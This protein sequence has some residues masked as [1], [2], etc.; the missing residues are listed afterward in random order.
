LPEAEALYR[1]ILEAEPNHADA[2]HLLGVIAHQT[3]KH[4]VAVEYITRAIALNPAAAEYHCNIGEAYRALARLNEAGSSFQ[5]ALALNPASAEAMNN[6]GAVLQEQGK[7]EEAVAHYRQAVALK[8]DYA[9]AYNNLGSALLA[10][11]K[12]EEAAT[13]I[14]QALALSPSFA[15]AHHNLGI[16]LQRKGHL[17][18]AVAQYRHALAL[19][20]DFAE[21]RISLGDYLKDVGKLDEAVVCY[22][23]AVTLNPNMVGAYNNLGNALRDQGKLDEAIA[24]YRQALAINPHHAGVHSNIVLVMS[25]NPT[26]TV[27]TIATSQREWNDWHARSL[28]SQLRTHDNDRTL[29]RCLRVGYV[30]AD[31]RGH[32][33]AFYIEP[34]FAAHDPAQVEVFCYSNSGLSDERTQRLKEFSNG[35]RSIAGIT[36]DDVA[37]LIRADGIDILVDLSNHTAGNR[38][39][40]FARKPAPVQVAYGG[41]AMT[42]GLTTMDYRLTDR[43]LSPPDTLEWSSEELIRL[44][45]ISFCCR[46]PANAPE[47]VPLPALA[48][49]YVTFGCFNNLVKVT[50]VVVSLWSR[51]LQALPTARLILKHRILVDT[52][53]REK[54]WRLFQDNGIETERIELLSHTP[55]AEYLAT[56]ERVDIALDP[57]PYNGCTTTLEALWMGV[58]VV[59]LAGV[60]ANGRMGVS[61]LSNVG[62]SQLIAATPNEYVKIAVA[63]AKKRKQLVEIRASLR[64][65]MQA[66]PLCD[67]KAL[68]RAVEA[69]YQKMWRRW[70]RSGH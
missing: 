22:R 68:A 41:S 43:F 7:L 39:L 6:M 19:K 63:L 70:C 4:E 24:C 27:E 23:E 16:V 3:G 47:I 67:A 59:T 51:I 49:G 44:P 56:Y 62:L 53:Q 12:T 42:T 9:Q 31:F 2:L 66:S 32:P 26:T 46:P 50:P 54:Y 11:W 38:L 25:Y 40:V 52:A 69:A 30:S 10:Q 29:E 33:I 61:I 14:Q 8:P 13:Y 15:E 36:D 5:Q 48:N 65:K 60:L 21:V 35:W 45:R 55:M 64:S 20:P 28:T 58:P 34:L 57:F 1:Q 37:D 17:S 18:E